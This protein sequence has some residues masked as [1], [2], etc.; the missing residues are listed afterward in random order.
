MISRL[1]TFWSILKGLLHRIGSAN[2]S[3]VAAGGAFFSMLSL[4]PGLAAVIALLGFVTDPAIVD[5][6]IAILADFVPEDAFA[7]IHDQIS[8]LAATNSSTLGW[9]TAISTG[10]ALWS[11]RLGTDALI[12]ALNAVQGTP[13]RGGVRGAVAALLITL[14]L[15]LVVIIAALA[16]VVMPVVLA[17]LPLGVFTGFALDAGRWFVALIVILSGIWVLY[18]FA[19]TGPGARVRW[20]NLGAVLAVLVWAAASWGFSYY[21]QNFGAYNEVYG[22]IGAVIALLMFLYITIFVVLLG[23]ALNAELADPSHKTTPQPEG[24]P[25]PATGTNPSATPA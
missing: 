3:L 24:D 8:R 9:T 6:Q 20:L 22:S 21:L 17:F 18:R 5:Q 19:P 12:R 10:T 14:A 4:F 1:K 7:L 15:I 13:T 23:G 11:A 16:M 25:T 2:L